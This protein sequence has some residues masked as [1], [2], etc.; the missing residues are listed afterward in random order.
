MKSTGKGA[1]ILPHGVLFRGNAEAEIRKNIIRKGYIKGI[2]G[3]AHLCGGIPDRDLDAL[4]AYWQ[5]FPSLRAELFSSA[6]LTG[7]SQPKLEA[8]QV[9]AAILG[10]PEFQAF[11]ATISGL[12]EYWQEQNKPLLSGLGVTSRPK[13]LIENLSERLEQQRDKICLVKQGMMQE[14]LTGKTHLY[15]D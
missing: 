6:E 9:K 12:F 14:L 5:V 3:T 8:S 4:I 2:I 15:Q 13:V 1:I 7:Y 11:K 10:H